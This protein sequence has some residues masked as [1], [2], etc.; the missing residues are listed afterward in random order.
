VSA[1]ERQCPCE[2]A[3]GFV[4]KPRR[5]HN[6][7]HFTGQL[8][9]HPFN[10]YIADMEP[11]GLD[12]DQQKPESETP[13]SQI[14][15]STI[16][17]NQQP[18]QTRHNMSINTNA[19]GDGANPHPAQLYQ[20]PARQAMV[21]TQSTNNHPTSMAQIDGASNCLSRSKIRPS[22]AAAR[23]ASD[24]D[25][26]RRRGQTGL[27]RGLK[28][29]TESAR[30]RAVD[31][32][33]FE[34][35]FAELQDNLSRVQIPRGGTLLTV[36]HVTANDLAD[37]HAAAP[38]APVYHN[39]LAHIEAPRPQRSVS[40]S[41]SQEIRRVK[42][43]DRGFRATLR[44]LSS[45]ERSYLKS[46]L[47][48]YKQQEV[49]NEDLLFVNK[50]KDPQPKDFRRDPEQEP[51]PEEPSSPED[52]NVESP[53]SESPPPQSPVE[54]GEDAFSVCRR[55]YEASISNAPVWYPGRRFY[56]EAEVRTE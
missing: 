27:M 41:I 40:S 50:Y 6:A 36:M 9:L 4:N 47:P 29:S 2:P 24:R 22:L 25:L 17:T 21:T 32:R 3:L 35:N 38:E 15:T 53:A 39:D 16:E 51:S 45:S 5:Y 46:G 55:A 23:S 43:P 1:L 52:D 20:G 12:R 34:I 10:P 14:T 13:N 33:F 37:S 11:P 31:R 44:R 56:G 48:A 26:R 8:G 18:F 30:A 49:I 28:S 19:W 54:E 42:V 7:L